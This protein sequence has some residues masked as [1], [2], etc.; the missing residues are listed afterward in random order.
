MKFWNWNIQKPSDLVKYTIK[1]E[2]QIILL[3]LGVHVEVYTQHHQHPTVDVVDCEWFG[4]EDKGEDNADGF[5]EG[6]DSDSYKCTKLANKTQNN[7][8][9][10]CLVACVKIVET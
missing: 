8:K 4:E 2:D 7:L 10:T 6:G 3:V 5:P 1:A 9:E